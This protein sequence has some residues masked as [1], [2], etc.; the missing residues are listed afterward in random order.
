MFGWLINTIAYAV[1]A[2]FW[3]LFCWFPLIIIKV[4][5]TLF[6]AINFNLLKGIFFGQQEIDVNKIPVAFWI[7]VGLSVGALVFLIFYRLLKGFFYNNEQK[8]GQ[9]E[10]K[11]IILKTIS[12]IF[13]PILFVGFLF[14]VLVGANMVLMEIKASFSQNQD[15]NVSLIRGATGD[16]KLKQEDIT[17]LANGN[18]VSY[19]IYTGFEWGQGAK[20]ILLVLISSLTIAWLL[21]TTLTSLVANIAQMF[22]QILLLPVFSVSQL[23]D[24]GKLF[25]KYLNGFWAK[26][27]VV[28]IYQISFLFFFVWTEYSINAWDFIKTSDTD[29]GG[30]ANWILSFV[31]SLVM[32]L[33]GGIAIKTISQEFASY[34]GGEGFIRSQQEWANRTTMG[35]SATAGLL[36]TAPT[37]GRK[38]FRKGARL[39]GYYDSAKA[40]IKDD[41]RAGRITNTE[42]KLRLN[43]LANKKADLGQTWRKGW[44]N[45]KDIKGNKFTKPIKRLWAAK[46]A[47]KESK[48]M[49]IIEGKM[50]DI[51]KKR[52]KLSEWKNKRAL[53]KF[54]AVK[55]QLAKTDP[56]NT[57]Q[58]QKLRKQYHKMAQRVDD[59][60]VN[61]EKRQEKFAKRSKNLYDTVQTPN[62]HESKD[63][64]KHP[65]YE[66]SYDFKIHSNIDDKANWKKKWEEWE[67]EKLKNKDQNNNISQ[68]KKEKDE[69]TNSK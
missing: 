30:L 21:G 44:E 19:N 17:W 38:I 14:I 23:T 52:S 43:E 25:K 47:F 29:F 8:T 68:E 12:A 27:W 55:D 59:K 37:L 9:S 18:V 2:G 50:Y 3:Y 33:G 6:G 51:S 64:R 62:T 67:E 7:F 5:T 15:L 11:S 13:F 46:E 36:A 39:T 57:K 20:L 41:Y 54:N 26:F 28:I 63:Y 45:S 56:S 22:Y 1:F 69:K 60:F 48:D 10:I 49:G 34:F 16:L 4:I 42:K 58:S 61:Q 32:I 31:F 40:Q 24:D 66:K 53:K 65:S 35:V